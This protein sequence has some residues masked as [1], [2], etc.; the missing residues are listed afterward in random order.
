[1]SYVWGALRR[2]FPEEVVSQIKGITMTKDEQGAVFDVQDKDVK[3]FEDYIT[4][5]E[6][7]A[8]DI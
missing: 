4:V 5:R 2:Y 8:S 6:R 1:M 3:L 7:G